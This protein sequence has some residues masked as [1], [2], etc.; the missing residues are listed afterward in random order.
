MSRTLPIAF[1]TLF[2]V[3]VETASVWVL[4]RVVSLDAAVSFPVAFAAGYLAWFVA[5]G[6]VSPRS[7]DSPLGSK[8]RTHLSV[9]ISVLLVVEVV[10]YLCAGLLHTSHI[11]TNTAALVA[12]ACWVAFG[13]RFVTG[14]APQ[15][16]SD[17]AQTSEE[18]RTVAE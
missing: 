3:A 14:D 7:V 10:V 11:T 4:T 2:A 12:V 17:L 16:P 5:F 8:L 18:P 1:A 13:W 6:V 9:G 15:P